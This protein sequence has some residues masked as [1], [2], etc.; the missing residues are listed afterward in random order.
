MWEWNHFIYLP[1]TG[2][3][4]PFHYRQ[5]SCSFS[6]AL[7]TPPLS[8]NLKSC[9]K[10]M[11][12]GKCILLFDCLIRLCW[13]RAGWLWHWPCLFKLASRLQRDLFTSTALGFSAA[14]LL[15]ASVL[16]CTLNNTKTTKPRPANGTSR[17]NRKVLV[18]IYTA[19]FCG[20]YTTPLSH[21]RLV[22]PTLTASLGR[23]AALIGAGSVWRRSQWHFHSALFH[24]SALLL[25]LGA[26]A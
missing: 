19:E 13:R 7:N 21:R 14:Q 12:A 20:A 18:L 16:Q 2:K 17:S 10:D 5:C 1:T 22:P 25:L 26:V 6:P 9:L 3:K 11:R 15:V 24:L 8:H 23:L 4:H